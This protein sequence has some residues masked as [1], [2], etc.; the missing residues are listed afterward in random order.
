MPG[1]EVAIGTRDGDPDWLGTVRDGR[2]L[3]FSLSPVIVASVKEPPKK[4]HGLLSLNT[5]NDFHASGQLGL[6]RSGSA[7]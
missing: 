7:T 2:R 6:E 3:R 5:L 1:K 4:D